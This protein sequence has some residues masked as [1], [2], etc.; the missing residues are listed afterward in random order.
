MNL[1]NTH[2][3]EDR[4]PRLVSSDLFS[5]RYF[6]ALSDFYRSLKH[7]DGRQLLLTFALTLLLVMPA[8]ALFVAQGLH[9]ASEN[10]KQ[11]RRLTVFLTPNKPTSTATELAATLTQNQRIDRVTLIDISTVSTNAPATDPANPTSTV[12]LEVIPAPHLDNESVSSLADHLQGLTG[13]DFVDLDTSR[14]EKNESAFKLLTSLARFSN[15]AALLIA[16]I[17]TLLV[18]RRD[19]QNNKKSIKLMRQIGA[20]TAD[21]RRPYLYR[22]LLLGILA[23]CLSVLAAI[24]LLGAVLHFADADTFRSLIPTAPSVF[25]LIMFFAI[26]IAA[27][28]ITTARSFTNN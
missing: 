9:N 22:S 16:A 14:L 25:Q 8:G 15:I 3:T 28:S 6:H 4:P 21:L 17:F 13:I 23:G 26:V 5:S 11:A 19:I 24:A 27:A 2:L 12:L 1:Q 10:L 18:S 20:T 7:G